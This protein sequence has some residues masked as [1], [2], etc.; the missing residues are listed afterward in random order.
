M[1]GSGGPRPAPRLLLGLQRPSHQQRRRYT[2]RRE[3]LAEGNRRADE[4]ATADF[5]GLT[6]TDP[7]GEAAAA[8]ANKRPTLMKELLLFLARAL[9]SQR[10]LG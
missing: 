4:A 2:G 7:T 5:T 3:E 1:A 10:G 9:I 6:A 8:N